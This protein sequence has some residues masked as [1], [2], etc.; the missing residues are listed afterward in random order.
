[1]SED[2][3]TIIL[4]VVFGLFIAVFVK[5]TLLFA[6]QPLREGFPWDDFEI[7]EEMVPM[8]DGVKLYTLILIPRNTKIPLP[9]LLERTPYNASRVMGNRSTSNL[10]VLLRHKFLGNDY[11]YTVQDIRGRFKSEGDYA[12]YRVPVLMI[13]MKCGNV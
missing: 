2:I 5:P 4:L 8:R 9:I 13:G 11:I 10:G 3:R 7:Q 12:M 6:Q 1:M